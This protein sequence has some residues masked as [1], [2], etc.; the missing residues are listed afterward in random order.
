MTFSVPLQGH[1]LCWPVLSSTL[2]LIHSN[3]IFIS[4]H[5]AE[6]DL[7]KLPVTSMS[8]NPMGHSSV[9]YLMVPFFMKHHLHLSTGSHPL[10]VLLPLQWPVCSVSSSVQALHAG[11]SFCIHIPFLRDPP[12]CR[13][14]SAA[15][16]SPAPLRHPATALTSTCS[17]KGI[18]EA[19]CPK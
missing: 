16:V 19:K 6:T 18:S 14:P 11:V 4:H 13:F 10:S 3:Q 17:V 2:S 9:L 8:L 12:S 1:A 15:H 7:V 5:S